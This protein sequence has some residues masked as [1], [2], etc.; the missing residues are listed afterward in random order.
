MSKDLMSTLAKNPIFSELTDQPL[1]LINNSAI[2]RKH[3]AGSFITQ[4]GEIWPY[5][6][7]VKSGRLD[8][9]KESF[10][11]R[12][13]VGLTLGEADVFWGMAF[14]NDEMPTPGALFAHSDSEVYLWS[15]SSLFPYLMNYPQILWKLCQQ[16]VIR[17]EQASRI[18][19]SLAF[20]PMAK[21][22]ASF[23]LDL[24]S[25][26]GGNSL[27][28]ELTLDDIA[29]RVGS[30]REE[31][32]RALYQLSD[33]RLIEITRTEFSLVNK[34]GLLEMLEK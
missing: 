33:K 19:E 15:R 29:A 30:T 18:V 2:Y 16:T 24:F 14:F 26:K 4:N 7:I 3:K 11:G 6:L 20:H 34:T 25:E 1:S 9:I 27:K 28:R 22:L 31:V 13:L 23:L 32:C 21:R 17:M 8:V 12:Q 5:F 10:S